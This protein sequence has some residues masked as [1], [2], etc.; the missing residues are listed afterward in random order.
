[1]TK[2]DDYKKKL[3]GWINPAEE[4]L[5]AK[6]IDIEETLD[7]LGKQELRVIQNEILQKCKER[8]GEARASISS[9]LPLLKNYKV[10]WSLVHR[11]DEDII[12]LIPDEELLS[13]ALDVKTF[14]DLNIKEEKVRAE[15][16]GR[17]GQKGKLPEAI[18]SLEKGK[19]PDQNRHIIKNALRIINDQMDNIFWIL[20]LNAMISVLSGIFLVASMFAFWKFCYTAKL[21]YMAT[22]PI[23]DI[24]IPVAILG[25]MGAYASNLATKEDFLFIKGP[26]WRYMLHY[27]IS[28]PSL[29][30]FA[31]VFIF[32]LEKSKLIFSISSV[33]NAGTAIIT[34][35]VIPEAAG[36]AYA[37]LAVVSGFSADKILR[38]MIDK[39]LKR[40]QEKAE[41]TKETKD[42]LNK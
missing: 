15:W 40:L 19:L 31:S 42:E 5:W 13:R 12:L 35:N 26:F 25:L 1:M 34:L 29:S 28:K 8:V 21:E 37:I 22:S 38:G 17:D 10:F 2:N 32:L 30:A 27:I 3:R 20:S 33:Q 6:L 39:V 11:I 24:V 36:Y 41:K 18:E 14:F 23:G 16:L 9:R 7:M 4:D